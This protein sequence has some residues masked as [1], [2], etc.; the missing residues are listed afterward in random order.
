MVSPSSISRVTGVEAIYR[1]FNQGNA[2]MLNQRVSIIGVGNDAAVY[3]TEK[4]EFFSAATVAEKYGW[5]SP[6]HLV[7]EQF[8]PSIG[9]A[10]EFPVTLIPLQ[11]AGGAVTAQSGLAVTGTAATANGSAVAYI[12]GIAAEFA[13]A[14]SATAIEI[15]TAAK[16]AINGVLSMP[17][18]AGAI[19][20][21]AKEL[22]LTA[23]WSGDVGNYITVEVE[24]NIPGITFGVENFSGGSVDPDIGPALGKIGNVWETFILNTF[25][26]SNTAR[27][28]K[29]QL[30]VEDRWGP[31][32]KKPCM[33]AHGCTDGL[34]TRT[35]ITDARKYDYANFLIVSTG[36]RELPF[37]VAAK[38]LISDIVTTANRNPAQNYKGR[39]TGL[40]TGPDDKQENYSQLNAS[41]M[42]GSSNNIKVGSVAELND[43][44]TF[45]HPV[46]E[47][48]YPAK[49]YVVDLVKLQNITYNVRLIME[50]D[51]LKGAPLVS[52]DTITTNP[53]A[54]SPKVIK[55]YFY[56]L[57]DS[58]ARAAIIQE[59][60][61][62]KKNMSVKIDS[63]N[64]KRVNVIFPVKLS[65]N[66]EVS[67]T[68]I[69]FGFYLG[70]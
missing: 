27:L 39:L 11:K 67:S 70:E 8:L 32:G 49:R 64:P 43:I 69:Y 60:D 61:F 2:A 41:I 21:E 10:A 1:N 37:V 33:I 22:T 15:L 65:G 9:P 51:S 23:K 57:A 14:K 25:S 6:L 18:I 26:Y 20:T 19:D 47:G 36:S 45:Y 38:G 62:T 46:E 58:L 66:V 56:N 35:A 48:K 50:Q 29:Y 42:K 59:P 63:E 44:V 28:D 4:R 17:A 54:V 3:D 55:T 40:H 5:G 12:G 52:D 53:A 68:D 7:A 13:V 31:L 16:T 30:F 34:E 24:S